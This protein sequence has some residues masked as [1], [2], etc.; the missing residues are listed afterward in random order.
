MNIKVLAI[1]AIIIT[2][3][4]VSLSY[5]SL[6]RVIEINS[7]ATTRAAVWDIHIEN[8]SQVNITGDVDIIT[9]PRIVNT[10]L[11]AGIVDLDV[12]FNNNVASVVYY[13]DIVNEGDLNAEIQLIEV[14]VPICTAKNDYPAE[15]IN[16]QNNVCSA[17]TYKIEK[18]GSTPA[19]DEL[20]QIGTELP[21]KSST[22]YRLTFS[23][24][25]RRLPINEVAITGLNYKITYE[26]KDN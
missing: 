6:S 14:P 16:D 2:I 5:A 24:N 12:K 8:L 13:F 21:A 17:I 10:E 26:M 18:V 3:L 15:V 9:A 11:F 19:D 20:I 22:R 4:G 7:T 1:I 23:Y 25:D